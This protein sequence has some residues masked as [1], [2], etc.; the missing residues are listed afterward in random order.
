MAS[1]G[2]YRLLGRLARDERGISS[3]EFVIVASLFFMMVFGFMDFSRAMW[4]WNAASKATQM[5]T[6]YAVVNDMVST[7]LR[8]WLG[9]SAGIPA[10]ATVPV[11]TAGTELVI[12]TSTGCNGSAAVADYNAAVFA[13]IVAEMQKAY[14]AIQPQNVIVEYRHIGLGFSA[15]PVGPDIDPLVTVRLTG[16]T[17]TLITP[18]FTSL[19]SI[20]MPDFA[21]SLTGEDHDTI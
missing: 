8:N 9:S 2:A 1:K 4:E 5:G 16:L 15:N 3:V 21:A 19:V 17:F 10:G 7:K 12:C 11:G 18:G 6:R 14:S 13:D 20:N